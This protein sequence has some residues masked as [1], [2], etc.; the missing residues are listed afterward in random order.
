M[1]KELL[2][3]I[4]NEIKRREYYKPYKER[5]RYM[6]D[7]IFKE[8][9][10]FDFYKA[11]HMSF[12]SFVIARM[13]S[14]EKYATT[15]ELQDVLNSARFSESIE[16]PEVVLPYLDEQFLKNKIHI[17]KLIDF[18]HNDYTAKEMVRDVFGNGAMKKC[19][20]Y[21]RKIREAVFESYEAFN[22]VEKIIAEI[23]D[24][25]Q[26]CEEENKERELA[27]KKELKKLYK[28]KTML[29][30]E[31]RKKEIVSIEPLMELTP[32]EL[33]IDVLNYIADKNSTYYQKLHEEVTTKRQNINLYASLLGEFNIELNTLDEFTKKQITRIN[34][35]DFKN[36]IRFLAKL[37][38][39]K[40]QVLE[41]L[42]NTNVE[43]IDNLKQYI[44]KDILKN[45]IISD[46]PEIF[47]PEINTLVDLNIKTLSET[48]INLLHT[49]FKSPEVYFL[50]NEL[51][52]K[53]LDVAS[54]N[55]I[56]ISTRHLMDYSF[57]GD[58]NFEDKIIGLKD[59]E[60][61]INENIEVLNTDI[62]VLKRI[63]LCRSLNIDIFDN[64]KIRQ[65]ILSADKFF[66]QN[67]DIDSY[68]GI[69]I[70]VCV[71]AKR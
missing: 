50:S 25:Y 5:Q 67:N 32:L 71:K 49:S 36:I 61:D 38:L 21:D 68:L 31:D 3:K 7:I 46:N 43:V 56:N 22:D 60:I 57:L 70:N 24:Y 40:E 4:D 13:V 47:K 26:K 48:S 69:D 44:E 8:N 28:L 30:S 64:G 37:C 9:E 45:S 34:Q 18:L 1:L 19:N 59:L 53:N 63:K 29:L 39:T 10:N 27:H 55:S 33:Q 66:I 11:E 2:E 16:I 58:V 20:K 41:I 52:K 6:L 17:I 54:A 14:N 51:I 35:D 12:Y 15:E 65:E 42:V 23:N 62:N